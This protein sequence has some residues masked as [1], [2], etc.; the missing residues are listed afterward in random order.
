M[1]TL[2]QTSSPPPETDFFQTFLDLGK[3]ETLEQQLD[4][5]SKLYDQAYPEGD[6]DN[7]LCASA[8]KARLQ[9]AP[10]PTRDDDGALISWEGVSADWI[11]DVFFQTPYMKKLA[12]FGCPLWF[13]RKVCII[14]YL[15]RT[16][17][18]WS[19]PMVS[20][21]HSHDIFPPMSSSTKKSR[22]KQ[23]FSRKSPPITSKATTF[24]SY[25]GRYKF[26]FLV[27]LMQSLRGEYVWLDLFGVDQ[28]AWTGRNKSEEITKL[29]ENLKDELADRISEISK[30]VL[31][32]EKWH[33]VNL[34][35]GQLWVLWEAFNSAKVGADYSILLPGCEVKKL[36]NCLQTE[37]LERVERALASIDANNATA[38]DEG[39]RSIILAE[40]EVV[41]FHRV[42]QQV[43]SS[44]RKWFI[45]VAEEYRKNNRVSRQFESNLGRLHYSQGDLT[46]AGELQQHIWSRLRCRFGREHAETLMAQTNKALSLK[47][48]GR[49]DEAE[50]LYRDVIMRSQRQLDRSKEGRSRHKTM[51]R[52]E[53]SSLNTNGDG[54][55][56]GVLITTK[57]NLGRL[58]HESGRTAEAKT[59]YDE[60]LH[61]SELLLGPHHRSTIEIRNNLSMLHRQLGDDTMA[62]ASYEDAVERLRAEF[63][64]RDPRTLKAI[65]NLAVLNR[66]QGRNSQAEANFVFALDGQR[67][68]LGPAHPDT[69]STATSYAGFLMHR[70][71]V[72]EANDL[73]RDTLDLYIDSSGLG[74]LHRD[75][76][77]L[78]QSW[79]VGLVN[80]G[81]LDE[82]RAQLESA[83]HGR[84]QTLGSHHPDTIDSLKWSTL[85][86]SLADIRSNST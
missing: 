25:T 71:R 51:E 30:T 11:L 67:E 15:R 26:S 54:V 59:M 3:V 41:G 47:Q 81:R 86:S 52:Y 2:I 28:F 56:L 70:N 33:N 9:T 13:V 46:N 23:L 20:H 84:R 10:S 72:R 80:H 85:I 44:I 16:G 22:I 18:V 69:L 48:R 75:T 49:V 19:G 79:G 43:C 34:T 38:A 45:D 82:G 7:E 31:L 68:I 21:V 74:A 78:L 42:N 58:L 77:T 17:Q 12:D 61:L 5:A 4:L 64:A 62:T 8:V 65:Q 24:V 50:R 63:T 83:Y 57:N 60:S 14:E 55:F 27:E 66:Q 1:A 32:V 40:M 73:Y 36:I 37:S 29:R 76:L 6:H 35:L 53:G 39:D